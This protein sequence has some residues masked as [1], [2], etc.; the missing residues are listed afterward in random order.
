[1]LR[2]LA[3]IVIV[4]LFG[5]NWMLP[6]LELGRRGSSTVWRQ[7]VETPRLRVGAPMPDLALQSL[8]GETVPLSSLKGRRV[9]LAFERSIDWC[10]FSKARLLD[11][12][13]ALGDVPDLEI[14][15]V[16][17]AEQISE[18][19]R[20]LVDEAG[21]RDRVL[22]LADEKSTGIRELG[23]LKSDPEVIEEGVPVPT[24]V[25][26]DRSGIVRF[27]DVREDY[28]VWLAPSAVQAALEEID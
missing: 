23:L 15:W 27:I 2:A 25:L 24:T 13:H 9:L 5:L 18:R 3:T 17:A 8:T 4:T 7:D 12:T 6:G 11:V 1:M 10:P 26:L 20:R 14:V 22:F 21:L 16:M 28:Q 19:T